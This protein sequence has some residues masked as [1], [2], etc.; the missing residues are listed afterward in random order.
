[1]VL[2][3]AVRLGRVAFLLAGSLEEEVA[4]AIENRFPGVR[5]LSVSHPELTLEENLGHAREFFEQSLRK[6]VEEEGWTM[7]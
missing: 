6:L 5:V 7:Q 4:R 3:E 1:M 2:E